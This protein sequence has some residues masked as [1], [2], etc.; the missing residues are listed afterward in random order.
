MSEQVNEQERMFVEYYTT[1]TFPNASRAAELAGYA[2]TPHPKTGAIYW[3]SAACRLMQRPIVRRLIA[4]RLETKEMGKEEVKAILA[5]HA[6]ASIEDILD[7]D[8]NPDHPPISLER[9]RQRG[10]LHLI[11]KFKRVETQIGEAIQVTESVEMVDSQTAAEKIGKIHALFKD[12]NVSATF[13]G[14]LQEWMDYLLNGGQST[15]GKP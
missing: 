5:D 8:A 13:Q 11:K 1:V 14:S 10:K 7:F 3:N 6:R 2:G 15:Q 4:Q 12:V 9:A